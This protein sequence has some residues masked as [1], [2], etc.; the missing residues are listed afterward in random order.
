MPR[1]T[2]AAAGRSPSGPAPARGPWRRTAHPRVG[3]YRGQVA[4]PSVTIT[5]RCSTA[6][7]TTTAYAVTTRATYS[8]RVRPSPRND[9]QRA[10]AGLASV[11]MSRRLFTTSI[12]HDS[13]PHRHRGQPDR[14]RQPLQLH[15]R[16]AHHRHQAE[17]HE[18]RDLAERTVAVRPRTPGVEPA[19]RDRR[20]A[21]QQQPPCRD[22]R[23][24]QARHRRQ[25]EAAPP[26]RRAPAWEA[27]PRIP[28]GASGRRARC[29]CRG[30]RRCSRWRS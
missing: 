22:R 26:P 1:R 25:Q 15:V 3:P 13:R 8:R 27:R 12:E 30:C 17:E 21:D 7:S 24:D 11:G 18:H 4:V 28:P 29:R 16:R 14:P 6:I 10:L 2:P 9:R 5:S 23:E 19:R 20:H